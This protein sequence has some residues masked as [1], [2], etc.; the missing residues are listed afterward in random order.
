[1][2]A[3]QGNKEE[4]DDKEGRVYAAQTPERYFWTHP[5]QPREGSSGALSREVK[6]NGKVGAPSGGMDEDGVRGRKN[7]S[8]ARGWGVGDPSRRCWRPASSAP[9][10][11][12]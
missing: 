10:N 5:R 2:A 4:E 6:P 3:A 9:R 11:P 8:L 1:M 12:P 7:S